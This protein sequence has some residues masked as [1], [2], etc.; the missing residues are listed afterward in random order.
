[1][2]DFKDRIIRALKLDE[3]LYEEVENDSTAFNQA[4][5]AVILSSAAAGIGML[6]QVGITGLIFGT[7]SALIGWYVW[8]FLT[9]QIGT[10]ML[11]EPGTRANMGELLRTLGFASSPGLIRI[12]GFIPGLSTIIFLIASVWMLL[13]MVIAVKQALDYKSTPRAVGVCFIGW[14]VQFILLALLWALLG[15]VPTPPA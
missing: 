6:G 1:M 15:G 14:L 8:A 4:M 2:A 9:F 10:K 3:A 13:A 5:L 11:P 7:I 12:F